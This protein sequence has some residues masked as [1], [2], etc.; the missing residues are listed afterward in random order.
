[1]NVLEL[2]LAFVSF[3][4]L[5]FAFVLMPVVS[6]V[7]ARQK[8][9]RALG[10]TLIILAGA[11]VGIG[12]TIVRNPASSNNYRF[13]VDFLWLPLLFSAAAT[14]FL[15]L[16]LPRRINRVFGQRRVRFPFVW[17]GRG[18]IALGL[19]PIPVTSYLWLADRADLDLVVKGLGLVG[20][21]IPTGRY[22]IRRGRRLKED[23]SFNQY[24]V[25]DP[26]PPVLY[27]RAFK[28]EQQFFVIG[29]TSKY[30][31][32]A[33]GLVADIS[34]PEH[35]IGIPFEQYFSD[36]VESCL[37]PFVALGSPEDYLAPEG[38]FRMYATD[39]D[40]MENL[41]RLARESICLLVEMGKSTN[42]HWEFEH[43]RRERL[44]KKLFVIT[45]HS[46]ATRHSPEGAALGWAFWAFFGLVWRLQGLRSVNW[47][48]FSNELASLG[49]E[50]GFED[51]GPG[52]VI[53]F[54]AEGRGILL[55]TGADRPADYV[56][57]IQAWM[58]G[59][60]KIGHH[61]PV[62]C[63]KCGRGF[64]ALSEEAEVN[65]KWCRD[66]QEGSPRKSAWHKGAWEA[67]AP[68]V[69][70]FLTASL[71]VALIVAAGIWIPEG[72]FVGRHIGGIFSALILGP[73]AI[74]MVVLART[75]PPAAKASSVTKPPTE[76][77]R[78]DTAE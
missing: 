52:S 33:K 14:A 75:D 8:G 7:L 54:D 19:L 32:Y 65:E 53:T 45:R 15:I 57:P 23:P 46:T 67:I 26:R 28:Q 4:L 9:Y 71:F 17:I 25:K 31:A 34:E 72:S 55:T 60:Q 61:V 22:L 47:K 29:P 56:K 74:W 36:A 12:A 69:Y 41:S 73:L 68:T 76:D 48:E 11:A 42:L 63:S 16:V 51:P 20:I 62:S 24:L 50:L 77:R 10:A 70:V 59:R 35:R 39:T 43:L 27:L 30:G 2:L 66:C 1:M 58:S 13:I 38:A 44:Q 21:L 3:P 18:V 64:H 49:Y 37:G 40:W 6:F 78:D 5:T